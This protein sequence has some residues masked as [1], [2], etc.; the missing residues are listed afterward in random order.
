MSRGQN[1]GKTLS[2]MKNQGVSGK[3]L[4]IIVDVMGRH[5]EAIIV[6]GLVVHLYTCSNRDC[7]MKGN[8][9]KD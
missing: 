5:Y 7:Q 9:G 2:L 6:V 1:S 3:K 4:P 8:S